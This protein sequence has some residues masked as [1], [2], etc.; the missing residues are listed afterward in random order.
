MQPNAEHA[1]Q[2]D[3]RATNRMDPETREIHERLEEWARWARDP[4][5]A[6]YPRQSLTEKAATYGRLGIPQEPLHRPESV[7]PAHVA[8]VDAAITRLSLREQ[9]V[10]RSY[11]L[12]WQPVEQLAR[13][14]D[15][16]PLMF[17]RVLR[18][19]RAWIAG[20]V[21]AREQ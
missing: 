19:A 1:A 21:E 7:M 3:R 16:H 12:H 20:Y 9:D 2:R 6:G 8:V 10:I 4:G 11:Y 13:R 15:M 18:R 14:I 5:I 17:H